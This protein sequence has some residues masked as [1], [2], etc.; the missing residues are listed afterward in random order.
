MTQGNGKR[1][2]GIFALMIGLLAVSG[3]AAHASPGYLTSFNTQYGTSATRLNTCTLCHT[4]PP[5]L[6]PYG[7]AFAAAGHSFTAIE[8]ADS[9]GD[10]YTNLVE[11]KALTFPGDPADHPAATTGSPAISLSPASDAFGSVTV[12]LSSAPA[13]TTITNSGTASLS[14]TGMTLS[15]TAD[16]ALN[17]NG[18]TNPCGSTAKA[19]A[20]GANCTV[21]VT[22]SP[23]SA[24]S[25]PGTLTIASNDAAKP[26]AAVSL[27]GT[28]VV[29]AVPKISVTPASDAFG[30]VTVGGASTPAISTIANT[31]TAALAVSGMTLSNATDYTLN[32]NGGAAPCGTAAKSLAAG[33]SC[34][35]AVTFNPKSAGA[36]TASL[37]VASN[38]PSAPSTTVALTGTGA[39]A[40]AP[41]IAVSP[42]SL[43][44]GSVTVGASSAPQTV[45]VSNSGNAN[46]AVGKLTLGGAN[47][48][49]FGLQN[50]RCSSQTLAPAATCTV[51]VVFTP[52]SAAAKAATLAIPSNDAAT[53][54]VGVS[55]SGT[56]VTQT[57]TPPSVVSVMPASNAVN[58]SPN[59]SVSA[60]FSET[61]NASSIS[62]ST[63]TLSANGSP[64][65]GTVAYS[66]TTA[67]F[68]PA[69]P[70]AAGTVHT[71]T[72]TT[73]A[74]DLGGAGIASNYAWS[75]T[76]LSAV[77]NT[78]T[79]GDGI[80]DKDD[81]YPNDNR[82]ATPHSSHGTGKVKIDVSS[83]LGA[84]MTEV[85]AM[86]EGTHGG[87]PAGY[88][89]N[90]GLFSFKINHGS[91]A[92]T[93]TLTFGEAVPAGSKVFM[94][95]SSGYKEIPGAVI[96]DNTVTIPVL[97][98]TVTGASTTS[99][100]MGGT[101]TA[102]AN[103]VGVASPDA[104]A[105]AA[106]GGGCSATGTA[107]GVPDGG[108][109]GLLL[110]GAGLLVRRKM[111]VI[112]R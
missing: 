97:P 44:I 54:N 77:D 41:K 65:A 39:T 90:D 46:L 27:T 10:G 94:V 100:T 16:Y 26:S 108:L 109:A 5:A 106:S 87:N 8:A 101:G 22:F 112:R 21:A 63:F 2:F 52:S 105:T 60:V 81:D 71:A 67:T 85:Q 103:I 40:A 49:E 78:D 6:N 7:S 3:G 34:T 98:T 83:I 45:T 68:T 43:A 58:V 20:A 91:G 57:N 72:V 51:Q 28:G 73:G 23:K 19:L 76:T 53:P 48:T 56:G 102:T 15:D 9:D 14:V 29:A 38:D 61:M 62:T 70:L 92:A 84:Y 75:F 50:D 66:G 30:S 18:G 36:K 93:V 99:L 1:L 88:H 17:V 32:L 107:S 111:S 89:F 104:A 47:A 24:G 4:S 74:Q 86:P 55:V 33:T 12:G 59:A 96:S 31:G 79:D 11:I 25:L 42:A 69:A 35:V 110:I 82:R 95:T 64:V 13:I 37:A 80:V